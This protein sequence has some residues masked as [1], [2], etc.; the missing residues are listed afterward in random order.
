MVG[1][2]AP[3]QT[4]INEMRFCRRLAVV[5]QQG[6]MISMITQT[7]ITRWLHTIADTVFRSI[8]SAPVG[9]LGLGFGEV[10]VA[11]H[12]EK[13]LRA[14]STMYDRGVS[15]I[16]VVN[17]EGAVVG[18]ISTSDLKDIGYDGKLI[19]RLC[20]TCGEFLDRRF[21]GRG[22][23]RLVSATPNTTV[24]ELLTLY[25]THRVHRVYL[26]SG[27][28]QT[29]LGV[30]TLTDIMNFFSIPPDEDEEQQEETAAAG[31]AAV[32]A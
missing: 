9:D 22:V 28:N 32:D 15:G 30:C 21:E 6:N 20:G 24:S 29:P 7:K 10:V 16:A 23:P 13:A 8:G 14:F 25:A 18:N 31:A 1:E 26:V 11:H 19:S 27:E 4:A 17:D 5:D 3:V 12:K 2:D